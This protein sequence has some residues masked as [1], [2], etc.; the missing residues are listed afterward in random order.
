MTKL[1]LFL[2]LMTLTLA[3]TLLYSQE[4]TPP[5]RN[6]VSIGETKVSMG[7][8]EIF[9][10]YRILLGENVQSCKV[11][12]TMYLG[13]N[14]YRKA[15]EFSGDIGKITESGFKRIR[16]DLSGRKERLA[17]RDISFRLDVSDKKLSY[18]IAATVTDGGN[19][20]DSRVSDRN[21]SEKKGI[22]TKWLVSAQIT[23]PFNTLSS[24]TSIP[25]SYGVMVGVAKRVGGYVGIRSNFIFTK[26]TLYVHSYD[27]L[28]SPTDLTRISDITAVGGFLIRVNKSLYTYAGAG[29]GFDRHIYGNYYRGN[30]MPSEWCLVED[31]SPEGYAFETGLISKVGPIAISAGICTIMF[32]TLSID[33]GLGV[34][35]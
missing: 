5:K 16:Y 29:Y 30:G 23:P 11:K 33:F 8:N 6:G 2:T 21:I 15:T 20:S 9:I 31:L 13:Y 19:I 3:A 25:T 14:P 18:N 34:M 1:K 4:L 24:H 17:G 22:G 27:D 32:K 7:K 26:P 12:V 28:A 35:F 10:D